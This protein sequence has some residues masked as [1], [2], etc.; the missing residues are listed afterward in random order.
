MPEVTAPQHLVV[1]ASPQPHCPEGPGPGACLVC[2][3]C[4]PRSLSPPRSAQPLPCGTGLSV[5]GPWAPRGLPAGGWKGQHLGGS[6]PRSALELFNSHICFPEN[7]LPFPEV[8][9]PGPLYVRVL[10]DWTVRP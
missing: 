8:L 7:V 9:W 6:M 3:G 5:S 2:G 4:F 10:V 1:M